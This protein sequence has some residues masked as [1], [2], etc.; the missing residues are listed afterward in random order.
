MP[1]SVQ[2]RAAARGFPV[3]N[4]GG[5]TGT[6]A[7]P[8]STLP[9]GP[10]AGTESQAWSNPNVDPAS[11]GAQLASPD[12][13]VISGMYG[14]PGGSN[15]DNTPRTHAAPMYDPT[16]PRGI[17]YIE[18]DATHAPV[19]NG[20]AVRHDVPKV[21]SM[22]FSQQLEEGNGEAAID[23]VTGQLRANA[24]FDGQQ[25]YGGGGPGPGGTNLPELTVLDRQFPGETY[26]TFVNAAEVPRRDAEAVQFIPSD[27][28]MSP[29]TG[30]GYNVPTSTTAQ[31]NIIPADVPAQ[32]PPTATPASTFSFWGAASG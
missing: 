9:S 26:K 12:P 15:P 25:G 18:A 10:A 22:Q 5:Q 20:V 31:Q 24:G 28:S 2:A 3:L 30:G 8:D 7:L 17:D 14:L 32:G 21:T 19:F 11:V 6:G 16:L 4:T 29:W 27:L 1:Q 13:F 23:K